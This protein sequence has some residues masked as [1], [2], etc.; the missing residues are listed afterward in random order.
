[1]RSGMLI[2]DIVQTLYAQEA[3]RHDYLA[4]TQD[5]QMS[6]EGKLILNRYGGFQLTEFALGQLAGHLEIPREYARRLWKDSPELLAENVNYWIKQKSS[7]RLVR[8]IG[9]QMR[10][11]VSDRYKVLD[12]LPLLEAITPVFEE[13]NLQI[14]SSDLSPEKFYLKAVSPQLRAEVKLNDV[15]QAG[16]VIS[17]SEIGAG[18]LCVK[19]LIFRLVC[20]NGMVLDTAKRKHH[21]GRK[22]GHDNIEEYLSDETLQAENKALFLTLRDVIK[23]SLTD[24]FF[25]DQ[26]NKLRDASQRIISQPIESVIET[27]KKRFG[28]GDQVGSSI[29]ET[30]IRSADYTQWGMANAVTNIAN[31]DQVGA[32]ETSS[33]LEEVGGKII[34]LNAS[35]WKTLAA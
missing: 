10:A 8:T 35:E 7:R 31:S 19:P 20:T 6:A 2:N 30:L 32:Y 26:V 28:L 16:V 12:N 4:L 3:E 11:F 13:A 21:V 22:N 18:S 24:S 23:G 5:M 1:M 14:V 17:N 29:L 27:T 9:S 33:Q 15:V 25:M 34:A